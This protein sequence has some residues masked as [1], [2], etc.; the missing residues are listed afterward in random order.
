MN[1]QKMP[2]ADK[3]GGGLSKAAKHSY[4]D[5]NC[6]IGRTRRPLLLDLSDVSDLL[7][8]MDDAGIEEALVRHN[9]AEESNP[10]L[11]N[12]LL[13]GKIA[14]IDRLHP[15]WVVLPHHTGE[16]PKPD[17]LLKEMEKSGVQ[18]ARL[19]PDTHHFSLEEWCSGEL[20][21]AFE[22]ARV[23]I[24]L[25][26]E[27]IDWDTLAKTAEAHPGLELIL[28]EVSYTYTRNY[29]PLLEKFDRIHFDTARSFTAGFIEDIV[30]KF[31]TRVFV[32]GTNMPRYSGTQAVSQLT[33]ADI[34]HE[35]KKAIAGGNL[36]QMLK[37]AF[38]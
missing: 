20:L 4:F 37:R 33:Y 34:S 22:E 38:S 1:K 7:R 12:E 26:G 35:E 5:C 16:F 6:S 18:S 10:G 15:Q 28:T 21:H 3:P 19:Y 24:L 17:V 13:N 29:Y 14:G 11:G 9:S 32:F 30:G 23:P 27:T 36:R 2:G 8:E 31:G 25:D